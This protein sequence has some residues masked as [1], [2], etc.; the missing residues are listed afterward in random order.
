MEST[1]KFSER[2]DIFVSLLPFSW[3]RSW[4]GQAGQQLH[5]KW[6]WFENANDRGKP[7]TP[8]VRGG[9]QCPLSLTRC[10]SLV[11]AY[12]GGGLKRPCGEIYIRSNLKTITPE[13]QWTKI[14]L[15][16]GKNKTQFHY[17]FWYLFIIVP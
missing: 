12:G 2:G 3:E 11:V 7:S 16:Q 15:D 14:S 10:I 9:H 17:D 5:Q 1:G 6:V 13:R 8:L 4:M